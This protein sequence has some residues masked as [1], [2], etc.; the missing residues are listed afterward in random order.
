MVPKCNS[1][2]GKITMRQSVLSRVTI[3][4]VL[5]YGDMPVWDANLADTE[6]R[7][8]GEAV[9]IKKTETF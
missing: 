3:F 1:D 6:S 4:R 9:I 5:I 8:A 2:Y 7:N